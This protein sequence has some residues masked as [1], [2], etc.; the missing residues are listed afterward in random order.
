MNETDVVEEVVEELAGEVRKNWGWI[1]FMGI[2]LVA[3]GAVGL[4]MS[5]LTTLV[6]VFYIGVMLLAGGVLILIDVF[7]AEGWKAKFWDVLIALAYIAAGIIMIA[8]P[9]A[10]AVWFTMFIAAFLLVSGAAR[11][12]ISLQIRSEVSGWGW[13]LVGGIASILLALMIF[14]KWPSSSVWVIGM[15]V[16]IE[17]IM[18]G[19]SMISIARAAKASIQVQ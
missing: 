1:M 18:Q 15:F 3:L 6:S 12:I 4:Y 5:G 7:K 16:A 11:I 13:T 14:A 10:S 17:M 8:N 19:I 9:G 2:L